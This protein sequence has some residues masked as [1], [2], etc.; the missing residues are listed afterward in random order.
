VLQQLFS[1]FG[2]MTPKSLLLLTVGQDIFEGII[3]SR[4]ATFEVF[5][6]LIFLFY[7]FL[8]YPLLLFYW[9]ASYFRHFL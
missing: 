6:H 5:A 3:F 4:I 9:R 7:N 2:N 1:L 8:D